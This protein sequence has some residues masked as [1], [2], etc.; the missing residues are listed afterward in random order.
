MYFK[1]SFFLENYA[2]ARCNH[3][4]I[5]TMIKNHYI[6]R[7]KLTQKRMEEFFRTDE[8]FVRGTAGWFAVHAVEV[9]G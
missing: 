2:P 7:G 3:L 6:G 8:N 5:T 1:P 9:E 4:A